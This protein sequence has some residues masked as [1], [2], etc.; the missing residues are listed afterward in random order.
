MSDTSDQ[1]I[2]QAR[3]ARRQG[4]L[5]DAK[6]DL[7]EAVETC[8][9]S[10]SRVE[11]A[12]ALKDLG[13]IECDL[14]NYD[15]ALQHYEEALALYRAEGD[16]LKIAHTVRHVGDIHRYE[17]RLTQAEKCYHEALNLYRNDPRTPLLDLANAIRPL[18]ILK[19]DTGATDEA[20]SLWEETRKLYTAVN[21]EAGVAESSRRLRLLAQK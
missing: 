13:Q 20:R 9:R 11:L 1:L 4:H 10:G 3:Q 12:R 19:F 17:G 14:D 6:R 16:V 2:Q 7:L 21:V 18:A 8:L 5:A 15:A